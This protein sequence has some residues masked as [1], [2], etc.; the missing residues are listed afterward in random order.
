MPT[1]EPGSVWLVGAGPGDP[2][3]LTLHAANALAAA[4]CVVYDALVS[5]EI[6]ALARPGAALEYAGKRGGKP[7]ASQPDICG[8]LIRLARQGQRVLRLKGGDPFVFGRGGEEALA[9]AAARI[10]FRL[11]PGVTAAAGGLAA[12]GIPM[13]HRTT[14]SAV[15]LLTGHDAAGGVPDALDWQAIAQ[16]APVL[17]FYMALRQLDAIAQ[18]LT[19]SGLSGETPAALI[20]H[21]TTGAERIVEAP[22]AEAA[23]AAERAGIEAPCL[24]VVGDVVRLRRA[25]DPAATVEA[26]AEAAEALARHWRRAAG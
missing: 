19:R 16:G 13:T 6:L 14:N 11:V 10:P 5:P 20:S 7:S 9:L 15:T 1:I 4:D 18:R 12:A 8:R 23:A 2:G 26:R 22:L 25:L 3:L 24:V 21:A 17:I